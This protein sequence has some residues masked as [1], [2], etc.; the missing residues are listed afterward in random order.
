MQYHNRGCTKAAKD[1]ALVRPDHVGKNAKE[2]AFFRIVAIFVT[3]QMHINNMSER[4]K[5]W[6]K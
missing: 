1:A 3:L 5:R 6:Q 2:H 4:K